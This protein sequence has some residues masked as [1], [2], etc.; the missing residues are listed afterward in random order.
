MHNALALSRRGLGQVWPNPSVG[1]VIVKNGKIIGR[2]NTQAGGRPHAEVEAIKHASEDTFGST[3]YVTLEPCSHHGNTP[4]CVNSIIKSG[5]KE[6]FVASRDPDPRVAGKGIKKLIDAGITVHEGILEG[7]A[8]EVNVGFFKKFSKGLPYVTL[9]TALT[10]DGKTASITGSSK[11]ITNEIAR[12]DSHMLRA[13]YDAVL[14]SSETANKDNPMLTCRLPGMESFSP[15]RIL[16]DSKRKTSNELSMYKSAKKVPLWIFTTI[17]LENSRNL[18]AEKLGAKLFHV[19]SDKNGYGVNLKQTLSKI[20]ELGITRLMVESGG[21][22]A[23]A[24]ILED[25]VDDIIIYRAPSLM[26]GDGL[27]SVGSLGI[28]DLC[29]IIRLKLVSFRIFEDNIVEKYN[30][31]GI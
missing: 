14:I 28:R 3:A 23:S 10:I 1:C 26:G 17:S 8:K 7:E 20:S 12:A 2:G 6:V 27:S 16:F 18:E 30:I 9:K 5:I 22:L 21:Q 15:I 11:W 13:S 19:S 25:L 4:P 31:T 24:L 29:D